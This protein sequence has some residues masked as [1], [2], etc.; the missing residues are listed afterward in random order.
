MIKLKVLLRTIH[1]VKV[2]LRT[3]RKVHRQKVHLKTIQQKRMYVKTHHGRNVPGHQALQL[4]LPQHTSMVALR[5]LTWHFRDLRSVHSCGKHAC[6]FVMLW[7]LM[8][9]ST[10]TSR[11]RNYHC[12]GS[13]WISSSKEFA[14]FLGVIWAEHLLWHCCQQSSVQSLQYLAVKCHWERL[15]II[16][17]A[18]D[19]CADKYELNFTQSVSSA[20]IC[21]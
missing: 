5:Y 18:K 1:Q 14:V 11:S 9:D 7:Q 19:S 15:V 12:L 10:N 20:G 8:M 21:T 17:Q 16:V 4:R 3:L 13:V 6:V 2:H